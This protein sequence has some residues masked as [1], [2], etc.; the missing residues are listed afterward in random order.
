MGYQAERKKAF[1]MHPVSDCQYMTAL[2]AGGFAIG[3]LVVGHLLTMF[4]TWLDRKHRRTEMLLSKLDDWTVAFGDA[5]AWL[6]TLDQSKTL[7]DVQAKPFHECARLQALTLLY[8]HDLEL[9]VADYIDSVREYYLWIVKCMA[10]LG[11]DGRL[12][13]PLATWLRMSDQYESETQHHIGNL[14]ECQQKL[15][16]AA[17]R[18]AEK[19]LCHL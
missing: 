9:F 15:V 1:T 19:L 6:M 3:G 7:A 17:K 18:K 11:P 5:R 14:L 13:I 12:T 8:F 4:D 10:T 2:I 16:A